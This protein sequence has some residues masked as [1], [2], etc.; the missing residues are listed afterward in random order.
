MKKRRQPFPGDPV[1]LLKDACR[2]LD[3]ALMAAASDPEADMRFLR[4]RRMCEELLAW[5]GGTQAVAAVRSELH[6]ESWPERSFPSTR[7]SAH[8]A[9]EPLPGFSDPCG[10]LYHDLLN[11]IKSVDRRVINLESQA[12]GATVVR[13]GKK[14]ARG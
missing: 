5:Q 7:L 13:D 3:R 11:W 14:G 9:T 4:A 12:M 1:E 10:G 6:I 2:S 8:A